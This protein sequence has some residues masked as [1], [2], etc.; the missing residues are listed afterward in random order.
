[1]LSSPGKVP[2]QSSSATSDSLVKPASLLTDESE[3]PGLPS[4]SRDVESESEDR[5]QG[6]IVPFGEEDSEAGP[7]TSDEG[8]SDDEAEPTEDRIQYL[9]GSDYRCRRATRHTIHEFQSL[10]V[11]LDPYLQALTTK[12]E[13][14]K[15]RHSSMTSQRDREDLFLFLFWAKAYPTR[16]LMAFTFNMPERDVPKRIFRVVKALVEACSDPGKELMR[17]GVPR[18][19][20]EGELQH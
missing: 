4:T 11:F 9:L 13:P 8:S 14:R 15:R 18:L 20:T 7:D 3:A 17:D 10:L 1:M 16:F 2:R 12:G 5:S 19:P 6:M